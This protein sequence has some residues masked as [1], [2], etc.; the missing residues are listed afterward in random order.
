MVFIKKTRRD[1]TE[2]CGSL[3]YR[4]FI[5]LIK[6]QSRNQIKFVNFRMKWVVLPYSE[7]YS[8]EIK[9]NEVKIYPFSCNQKYY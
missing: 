9:C 2:P 3:E 4:G 7:P 8:E 6:G 1:T 5:E